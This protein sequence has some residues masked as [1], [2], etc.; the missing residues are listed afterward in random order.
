[1]RSV[2]ENAYETWL[3]RPNQERTSVMLLGFGKFWIASRY[4]LQGRTLL[5]VISNPANST[6]SSPNLNFAGLRII[7]L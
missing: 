4:F 3:T 5:F 6:V 1:M 7:P 2:A